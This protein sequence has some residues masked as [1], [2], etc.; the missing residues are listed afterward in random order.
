MKTAWDYCRKCERFDEDGT[1]L[2]S[3]APFDYKTN[4]KPS[5]ENYKLKEKNNE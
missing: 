4:G 2:C 5:C 1:G 3:G